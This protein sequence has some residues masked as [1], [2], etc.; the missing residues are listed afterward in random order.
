MDAWL[1]HRRPDDAV[2]LRTTCDRIDAECEAE[3]APIVTLRA[4]RSSRE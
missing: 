4:R 3:R 2:R 1:L